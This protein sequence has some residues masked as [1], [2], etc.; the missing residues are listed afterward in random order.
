MKKCAVCQNEF[1]KYKSTDK[2]C[3]LRCHYVYVGQKE[4]DNKVMG[5]KK[6]I[7]Q[8][9]MF[10]TLQDLINKIVRLIDRGHECISSGTAYG[11]YQVDAGHYFSVG[12]NASLRYNL[13]NIFAQSRSDNDRKGGKGSNYGL[14]LK[15]VFGSDVRDEIEGLV[16]KYPLLK[17]TKEEAYEACKKARIIIKGLESVDNKFST[18]MRISLRKRLNLELGIYK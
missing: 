18:E 10:K 6:R 13:L 3:S 11:K 15:E 12:S 8:E 16:S 1:T 7:Q 14:R 2:V 17:L 9:N 5:Y 4:I